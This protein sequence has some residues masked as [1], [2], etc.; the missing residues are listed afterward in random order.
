[1]IARCRRHRHLARHI[2]SLVRT[3]APDLAEPRLG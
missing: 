3:P 1:V 2:Q